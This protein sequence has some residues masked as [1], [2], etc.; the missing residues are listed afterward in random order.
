MSASN[1]AASPFVNT[2]SRYGIVT[3]S[4]HWLTALLIVTLIPLGIIAN[5]LPYETNA[6]LA[7]KA[8]L[9]SLHKTLGVT[10]F[11][12]ALARIGWAISQPKPAPLHPNRKAE[13][14][15]AALVHWLLYA[16][17]VLVPLTGWIHHAATTGFAPI[18]WPFGQ[19]LPFVPK[20]DV[21]AHTFAAL[22]IIFERVLV[23]S[24]L[25][26][27]IGALKHHVI[28][29]D[30]TLRR[31]WAG[32]RSQPQTLGATSHGKAPLGAALGIY[33]VAL[34]IGAGLGLF[35]GE[36]RAAPGPALQAVASDWQVQDGTL[37]ITITQ[38]GN[39]VSGSFD[40]WTAAIRF[41]ENATGV[42]GDV[43][44]TI[45]IGSVTLGSVTS[46]ALGADFFDA[47]TFPT[48]IFKADL[49]QNPAGA[50]YLAEGSLTLKGVE[51][52]LSLPFDLTVED[53]IATMQAGTALD[54]RDFG[55]GDTMGDEDNL[56]FGVTVDI[57]LSARRMTD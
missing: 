44:A 5:G 51:L 53:G 54:R 39:S 40:D 24:I 35:E 21:T 34:A 30:T 19:S 16:S 15:L 2:P 47:S 22:H 57:A 56:A 32:T 50:G 46:Q 36:T 20:D 1:A 11:F 52:P 12:V 6:E 45:A 7:Q 23:L 38:F 9:F 49:M 48:A 41:D 27:V 26:H 28:D 10:V 29:K 55:I 13:T 37:G 18:W 42:M 25:L 3:R 17:L 33:A 4:F 8:L 43:E 31:M 14:F